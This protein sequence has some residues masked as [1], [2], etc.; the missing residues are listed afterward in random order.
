[1]FYR[2]SSASPHCL[3]TW[4]RNGERKKQ[5]P[6]N[7]FILYEDEVYF[8]KIVVFCC[9]LL[10]V[11]VS[12]SF[13]VTAIKDWSNSSFSC[14]WG[15]PIIRWTICK[16]SETDFIF[17]GPSFPVFGLNTDRKIRTRKNFMF[18][19]FSRSDCHRNNDHLRLVI[20]DNIHRIFVL[21]AIFWPMINL[22]ASCR[23]SYRQAILST[24]TGDCDVATSMSKSI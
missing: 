21:L 5:F 6:V 18:G 1:M 2:L 12:C 23:D 14:C 3:T 24:S 16:V 8:I 10:V 7:L 9:R 20:T 22:M 11:Y 15:K 17:S 13:S 19:H 4:I